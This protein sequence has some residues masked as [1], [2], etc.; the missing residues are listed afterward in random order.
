MRA[1]KERFKPEFLNRIDEFVTFKPLGMEQLIPIVSLELQK[2]SKR[3]VDRKLTL[4]VTE[5]AKQ[6]LA[7]IGYDPSYGAR[8]LKRTIQ[9]E[10]ETP[11]AQVILSGTAKDNSVLLIDKSS[12][13]ARLTIT[14]VPPITGETSA[15]GKDEKK[16]KGK[17]LLQE[18]NDDNV[19]Q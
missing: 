19:M 11:I 14:V 17:K 15:K 1:L 2:V 4:Q 18:T 9:R 7:Q 3:L 5:S 8:P 16:G 12:G 13:D 6:W 10:V